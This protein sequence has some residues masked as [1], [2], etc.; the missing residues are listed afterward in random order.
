[1]HLP[2]PSVSIC[3]PAYNGAAHLRAAIDSAL[4]Q[5]YTD[6]ELVVVDDNSSDA[7]QEIATSYADK[8]VRY[9]RNSSNLGPQVTWNRCRE[10][11]RGRYFK[12]M[13]QD[14]LLHADCL[15]RQVE[16]LDQDIERRIAL[17]FGSRDFVDAEGRKIMGRAAFGGQDRDIDAHDL[18]RSCIRKGTNLIGE[19]GNVLMRRELSE[20]IGPFD[21]TYGYMI[22]LDYWFRA[23]REGSGYYL[24]R[25]LSS[26]RI[27]QGSWSVAIGKRQCEEFAAFARKYQALPEYRIARMDLALGIAIAKVNAQLRQVVYWWLLR[28]RATNRIAT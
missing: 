7:T 17:V 27:S 6:F 15:A 10:E 24:A 16:V 21:G 8:R 11:A 20:R 2:I 23:L 18:I 5:T 28:K 3:M 22:D 4:A 14:D 1:M 26:F 12:L 13:P 19:P 25:P 9:L